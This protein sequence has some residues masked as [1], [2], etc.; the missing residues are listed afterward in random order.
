MYEITEGGQ[1]INGVE[2]TTYGRKVYEENAVIDVEAGTTGFMGEK[3]DDG[4]RTF[5]SLILMDGDFKLIPIREEGRT[6]G[7]GLACC[8][9]STMLAVMKALE[10]AEK[11]LRET[12]FEMNP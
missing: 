9:D 1:K 10:F 12:C 11:A 5:L 6:I 4:G 7:F 8:G 2:V 3:R